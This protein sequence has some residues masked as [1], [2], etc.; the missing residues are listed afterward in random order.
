MSRPI[1]PLASYKWVAPRE[2]E[3]EAGRGFAGTRIFSKRAYGLLHRILNLIRMYAAVSRLGAPLTAVLAAKT[4][5]TLIGVA[6]LSVLPGVAQHAS[7]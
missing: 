2:I 3:V 4:Y 6:A 1:R 7:V 5:P